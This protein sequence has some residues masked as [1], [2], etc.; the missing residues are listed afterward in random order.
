MGVG[1]QPQPEHSIRSV[2]EIAI[3]CRGPLALTRPRPKLYS[4]DRK[5]RLCREW[6]AISTLN[7]SVSEHDLSDYSFRHSPTAF[8]SRQV[9]RDVQ[10]EAE[11]IR[12]ICR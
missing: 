9:V 4:I 6:L 7:I 11:V 2:E 12:S 10:R 3:R 5:K 1:L 8:V